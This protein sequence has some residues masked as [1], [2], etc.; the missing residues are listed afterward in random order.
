MIPQYNGEGFKGEKILAI[1][2]V[3]FTIISSILLIELSI[4]QR[5]QTKIELD[6]LN[7]KIT[8]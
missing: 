6:L 8:P 5:K 4:L 1:C 2:A 3:V 7:K